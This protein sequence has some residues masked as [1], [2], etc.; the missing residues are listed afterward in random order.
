M[1]VASGATTYFHPS[2]HASLNRS[3]H[4]VGSHYGEEGVR[5]VLKRYAENVILPQMGNVTLES[6]EKKFWVDFR[7]EQALELLTRERTPNVLTITVARC[8]GVTYL[9]EQGIE[10]SPWFRCS[11]DYLMEYLAAR[12]GLHFEVCAYDEATGAATYCFAKDNG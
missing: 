5:G 2:F 7:R 3:L 4:Y 1:S 8:P 10:I 12:G 6:I 9:R 11:T